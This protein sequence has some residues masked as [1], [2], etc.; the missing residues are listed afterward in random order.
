MKIYHTET[1]ADYDALINHLKELDYK[2]IYGS[3]F[4]E[5]RQYVIVWWTDM[6]MRSYQE[7]M[8]DE[9]FNS[10]PI[11]EYKAADQEVKSRES[12]SVR[13]INTVCLPNEK[14][15]EEF[16]DLFNKLVEKYPDEFGVGLSA[17]EGNSE[18]EQEILRIAKL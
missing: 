4:S 2:Y 13:Y 8:E 9:V 11:I 16:T 15:Q 18:G 17:V 5:E 1:Q 6:V 3:E 10:L 7:L 12:G 14:I